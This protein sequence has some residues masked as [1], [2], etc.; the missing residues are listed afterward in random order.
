MLICYEYFKL[1][2]IHSIR[3]DMIV[4]LISLVPNFCLLIKIDI[5]Q[6]LKEKWFSWKLLFFL[7]IFRS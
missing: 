3:L 7:D 1:Y 4:D 6:N 2:V 5:D